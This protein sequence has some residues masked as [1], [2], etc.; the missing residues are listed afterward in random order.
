M[1]PMELGPDKTN[2]FRVPD[3]PSL[4]VSESASQ[5]VATNCRMYPAA[6]AP[7]ECRAVTIGVARCLK[8]ST[9][10]MEPTDVGCLHEY[11]EPTVIMR[12]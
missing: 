11:Y 5:R 8:L 6:R 7:A 1:G 2:N 4:F 12:G 10:T 9:A 3:G